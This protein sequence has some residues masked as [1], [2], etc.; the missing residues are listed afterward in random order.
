VSQ[1]TSSA[2]VPPR[3]HRSSPLQ[4]T[5]TRHASTR[6]FTKL[7]IGGARKPGRPASDD[8]MNAGMEL[9]VMTALMLGLGYL[10]DRWL[11]TAPWFMIGLVLFGLI[12]SFVRIRYAY[13]AKMQEHEAARKARI[14]EQATANRSVSRP[15][16]RAAGAGQVVAWPAEPG[17]GSAGTRPKRA[18][19]AAAGFSDE[20]DASGASQ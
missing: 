1:F 14:A 9:A 5:T 12:G 17:E 3:Q 13:E 2:A 4:S 10:V 11:G 18:Q 7:L 15:T 6:R 20:P 16:L 8:S 19:R